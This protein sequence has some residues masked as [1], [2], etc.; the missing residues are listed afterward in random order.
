MAFIQRGNGYVTV[1]LTYNIEFQLRHSWL[2]HILNVI[3]KQSNSWC[4]AEKGGEKW[5]QEKADNLKTGLSKKKSTVNQDHRSQP[6][7]GVNAP[8]LIWH[9]S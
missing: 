9:Q 1:M 6:A 4:E 5:K 3:T 8:C 7:G 2:R